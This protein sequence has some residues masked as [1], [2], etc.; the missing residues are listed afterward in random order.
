VI[1]IGRA[2][3]EQLCWPELWMRFSAR[4]GVKETSRLSISLQSLLYMQAVSEYGEKPG[5]RVRS[6]RETVISI[7]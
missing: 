1:F 5:I 6:S 2:P 4:T 7:N 3:G